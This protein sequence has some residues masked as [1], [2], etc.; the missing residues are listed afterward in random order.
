MTDRQKPDAI[1]LAALAGLLPEQLPE[2]PVRDC[3]RDRIL[4]HAQKPAGMSVVR[5][6]E[7]VWKPIL[8]GIR[9][10]SLRKGEGTETTLWK[11]DAGAVL[12]AH[13]HTQQE[14]CLVLE[15]SVLH[16]GVEYFAGDY[17]LADAG[18][19]HAE[20]T[21]TT[22]ALLLIRSEPV[23]EPQTLKSLR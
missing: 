1:L 20:F 2:A 6:D 4:A 8:P 14:E 23:P 10:K 17:L 7:G 11:I 12:P 16:G 15:G 9:I 18:L 3:L 21:T 5:A 22:G 19:M 13:P